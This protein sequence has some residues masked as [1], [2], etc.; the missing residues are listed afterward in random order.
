MTMVKLVAALA[1]AAGLTWTPI[2][3]W[4]F[5]CPV[6]IKQ[7]EEMITKAER[8]KPTA[9][10]RPFIDEAKKLV[11]E[12]KAHHEQAKT[13]RDHADAVRKAKFAIAL[14]EEAVVLQG[15]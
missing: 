2:A 6:V 5:T 10:T 1:V 11:A 13:K 4:G 15:P 3:A 12:A 8:G 14:A 7:A 9:D